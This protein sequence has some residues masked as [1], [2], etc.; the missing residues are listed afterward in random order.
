MTGDRVLLRNL[1]PPELCNGTSLCV[2][3]LYSHLIEATILT[4]YAKGKD[5][6]TP[7]IPLIPADL[8]F[9]FKRIQ[10]PICLAFAKSINKAQEQ[11]LKIVGIHLQNQCFS[12]GQLYVACS[13]VGHPSNLHILAPG[14]KTQNIVYPAAL[15]EHFSQNTTIQFHSIWN[16]TFH[17]LTMLS[18]LSCMCVLSLSSGP[19]HR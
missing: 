8:L 18:P 17:S 13:R 16:E 6:F 1:N 14:G 11:Y 4:G 9:D 15:Q 7:Q 19:F 3:N 12:H 10:F 5:V 2:K